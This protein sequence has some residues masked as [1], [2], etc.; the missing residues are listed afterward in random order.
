LIHA[1]IERIHTEYQQL[2]MHFPPGFSFTLDEYKWAKSM[3]NSRTF[4]LRPEDGG[5]EV[6]VPLADMMDHHAPH[7]NVSW[8]GKTGAGFLCMATSDVSHN[9]PLTLSYGRK[10]NGKL[11]YAYGFT[12][13]DNRNDDTELSFPALDD[14]S[15]AA[16]ISFRP[17]AC[18]N[19]AGTRKMFAH[20]RSLHGEEPRAALMSAASRENELAVLDALRHNCRERIAGFPALPQASM[21]PASRLS[22]RVQNALRVREGELQVLHYL[23]ALAEAGTDFLNG[24]AASGFDDYLSELEPLLQAEAVTA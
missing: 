4:R 18:Y 23:L 24:R 9:G 3:V 7:H 16:A 19:H 13:Q 17:V 10:G 2:R 20:L 6:M 22:S 15:G 11:F 14:G 8:A 5:D 12:L 1:E 21:E